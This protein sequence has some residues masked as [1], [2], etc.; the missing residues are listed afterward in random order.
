MLE[1]KGLFVN[2]GSFS[3]N[4]I[5]LNIREKQCHMIIGPTGSGKTVLIESII[6]FIKPTKGDVLLN[7]ES[8]IG[9][10]VEKR[11]FSY[12]PQDLALFPNL[13]VEDNI[14]YGLRIRGI[15]DS[16]YKELADELIDVV[17]I[18]HLLKRTVNNLSGGERQRIALVRA[19]VPGYKYIILDEPLSALHEG[20][21]QELWF[22]IK[23]L[24][25]RLG[26]TIL[27]VTHNLEEAFFLGDTISIMINGRICQTGNKSSVFR[28]PANL[29]VAIFFGIRNLFEVEIVAA[30]DKGLEVFSQELNTRLQ[31]LTDEL[32]E[33]IK[34]NKRLI[35]GI[36]AED[37]M[38]LRRDL[39]RQ[40][41]DNLLKGTITEIFYKGASHTVIFLPENSTRGIEIELP[42]YAFQKL[43]LFKG[44]DTAISLK[45]ENIFLIPG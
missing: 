33:G 30:S 4:D 3:L 25:Q 17:G 16:S 31:V 11:G 8:M 18:R 35:A 36:R 22:L 21:K 40:N 6:G 42:D 43:A 1:I 45:K 28:R 41:Q 19:V 39:M 38:I 5:S 23:A 27:M 29:D 20:L 14:L 2:A 12:V 24:Q 26:L 32:P 10:P 44:Q 34:I 15:K 37:V 7:N 9:L 13:S